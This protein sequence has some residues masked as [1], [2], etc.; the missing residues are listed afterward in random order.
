VRIVGL[1]AF[2]IVMNAGAWVLAALAFR[3]HPVLLGTALLAFTFGLRHA[4]DADHICA[5]DNVTR[6]LMQDRQK[7]IGVGFFFSLGH[8]TVVVGLTLAVAV[9]AAMVKLR[10]PWLQQAGAFLGTSVSAA[11]LLLIAAINL[12]VLID[13]FG[14]LTRARNGGTL[15]DQNLSTMLERRGL[16]GRLF[17]PLLKIVDRSW[18]MYPVG[19]LFGLGFDTATE[20]ALLGIAAVEAARALPVFSILLFPLLFTAGMS[21]I[22]TTDGIL[23]VGVYGW[24][25]VRPVRKL[26][27]NFVIT[28]VSVLVAL[29]VGAGE[30]ASLIA[31]QLSFNGGMWDAIRALN[32]D[33]GTLGFIIVGLFITSWLVSMA[34]YNLLRLE[35]RWG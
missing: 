26:Y 10:L 25:L 18:K 2:L 35:R 4:V 30:A 15:E 6:K 5:I 8:S 1:Y 21:L 20:V 13:I 34:A 7:P 12:F 31:Q 16:L 9:A 14:A 23:M 32:G 24:A 28:L 22:D 17:R 29:V 11:F 27:Y 3:S 33:L 19:L